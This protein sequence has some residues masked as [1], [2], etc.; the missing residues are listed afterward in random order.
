MKH[1]RPHLTSLLPVL[2]ALLTSLLWVA[3]ARAA[4]VDGKFGIGFEDTLTSV[5][6]RQTLF[7][8][9]DAPDVRPG[10]LS[11]RYWIGN[12]ALEGVVGASLKFGDRVGHAGFVAMGAH[13]AAFRAPNVNLSIGARGLFAWANTTA[14]DAELGSRFGFAVEVPLR[15][16]YFLTPAFAVAAAVGP[17]LHFPSPWRADKTGTSVPI[18][19]PLTTGTSSWDLALTR[20]EF[21]GGLG[22][23]YYFQ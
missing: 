15:V 2:V 1:L 20:G 5:G 18:R 7:A 13:Y 14:E 21:S 23:T 4:A 8:N 16:E 12:V 22:F 6:L 17:V 11:A 3:P 9:G 19:N 10:G